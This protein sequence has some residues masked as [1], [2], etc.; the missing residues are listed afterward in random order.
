MSDVPKPST[1]SSARLRL[2]YGKEDEAGPGAPICGYVN[3][4]ASQSSAGDLTG[5]EPRFHR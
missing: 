5:N 1:D 2:Y 4:E 3:G